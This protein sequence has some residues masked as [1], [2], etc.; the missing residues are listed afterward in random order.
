MYQQRQ[1]VVLMS[2]NI[3]LD[4]AI[5]EGHSL[6]T[7]TKKYADMATFCFPRMTYFSFVLLILAAGRNLASLM[8]PWKSVVL[9]RWSYSV[10]I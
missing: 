2:S 1:R 6:R 5:G 3:W 7:C 10:V 8:L 9:L 4:A